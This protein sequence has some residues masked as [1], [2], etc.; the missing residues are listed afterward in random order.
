MPVFDSIT[1]MV[2]RENSLR[3]TGQ[4]IFI[5]PASKAYE[6][7]ND[8]KTTS[9]SNFYTSNASND[10]FVYKPVSFKYGNGS[11]GLASDYKALNGKYFKITEVLDQTDEKIYS[12]YSSDGKTGVFLK[13]EGKE[14]RETL[15]YRFFSQDWTITGPKHEEFIFTGIYEKAKQK[16][17]NKRFMTHTDN[18]YQTKELNTG[19]NITYANL[20]W[21]CTDVTLVDR[22]NRQ[23]QVMALILKDTASREI[24]VFLN[25]EFSGSGLLI[26]HFKSEDERLAEIREANEREKQNV[27]AYKLRK[28]EMT[29]KYGPKFGPVVA[30]HEVAIGMNKKMCVDA[31]GE[32]DHIN[33]TSTNKTGYHEQ[34]VYNLRSYIYFDNNLLTAIQSTHY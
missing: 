26:S 13:L 11:P 34:W 8:E 6:Q 16:Y 3:L 33:V 9:Y 24:A 23:Y 10:I 31:W 22:P 19:Q 27:Q 25:S 30:D 20:Q 21:T 28:A 32:P 17:L 2:T 4:E 12:R 15:Y 5:V 7:Q 14:N 18:G 29:K 1:D